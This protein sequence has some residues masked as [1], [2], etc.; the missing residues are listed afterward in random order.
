MDD[1]C[2]AA[3]DEL[4]DRSPVTYAPHR[5]RA[6]EIHLGTLAWEVPGVVAFLSTM[7]AEARVSLLN[8]TSNDRD[9]LLV[10]E[11]DVA[12][13]AEVI[14]ERL[15]HDVEGLREAVL[16]Q[17]NVRRSHSGRSPSLLPWRCCTT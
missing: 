10:A 13:A 16:E 11:A 6:F 8:I 3:F 12:T 15:Q 1:R 4:G 17:T 9:Y 7:L 5:W 14:A 2:R